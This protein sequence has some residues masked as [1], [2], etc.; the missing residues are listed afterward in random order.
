MSQII[1]SSMV[2]TALLLLC[3]LSL[4]GCGDSNPEANFD[5]AVGEHPAG[6]LPGGHKAAALAKLDNCTQC[7]GSDFLGG[8]SKVACTDCHLGNTN[9]VH[10]E[11]WGQYAYALHGTYVTENTT[12]R[13]ATAV[14]HG[15]DLSGVAGSGP[16][17]SS[18]HLGGNLAIHPVTWNRVLTSATGI[19]P[20]NLPDHADYVNANG[21]AACATAACHG[22][23]GVGVFLSGRA[24]R[25]CHV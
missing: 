21:S 12:A 10:P 6:W 4:T 13:C 20:T 22:P 18:C 9:D 11:L 23:G 14:C 3:L 17:C 19:Y 7:H 24:C 16:S 2:M 15:T 1:K 25:A 8:T 5:S